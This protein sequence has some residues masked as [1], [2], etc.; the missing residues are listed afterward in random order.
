M[1]YYT[2]YAKLHHPINFYRYLIQTNDNDPEYIQ[3]VIYDAFLHDIEILPPDIAM[4]DE[5]PIVKDNK[6]MLGIANVKGVDVK[7]AERIKKAKQRKILNTWDD[8][9]IAVNN[10]RV[11][12]II[13]KNC[14]LN[15]TVY[16]PSE[17]KLFMVSE[18]NIIPKLDPKEMCY[19]YSKPS[20]STEKQN[21]NGRIDTS[22]EDVP[23]QLKLIFNVSYEVI[24]KIPQLK[25]LIAGKLYSLKPKENNKKYKYVISL[26]NDNEY[27]GI[28]LEREP[29]VGVGEYVAVLCQN[30]LMGESVMTVGNMIYTLESAK[31]LFNRYV[32]VFDENDVEVSHKL[33]LLKQYHSD[34]SNEN[35]EFRLFLRKADGE[36]DLYQPNPPFAS[37]QALTT[38]LPFFIM[39]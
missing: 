37:P 9:K 21:G 4:V 27:I 14:Y 18:K 6:I 10:D 3:E 13:T 8:V 1:A 17:Q 23:P 35:I 7:F 24:K 31:N 28:L 15:E 30:V 22:I 5:N 34:V 20:I 25:F 32:F 29:N 2:A 38:G 16:T 12:E 26:K 33:E 19:V 36:W 11:F 39:P